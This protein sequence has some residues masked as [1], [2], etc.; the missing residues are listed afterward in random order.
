[1]EKTKDVNKNSIIR[2]LEKITIGKTRVINGTVVTRW[3]KVSYETGT[4]GRKTI[5]IND[6]CDDILAGM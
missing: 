3:S 5:S 2:V 1:M 4:W 6:A